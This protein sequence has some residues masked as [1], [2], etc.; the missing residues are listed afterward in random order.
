M[1]GILSV[2]MSHHQPKT[3]I[4]DTNIWVAFFLRDDAFHYEAI[5][6]VGKLIKQKYKILLQS[7]VAYETINILANRRFHLPDILKFIKE[8]L[9]IEISFAELLSTVTSY[10]GKV[11]LKSQ[12]FI[13]FLYCAKITPDLFITFDK[14]LQSA[15]TQQLKL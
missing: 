2:L 6:T 1:R 15:V 4:L 8:F 9:V 7:P 3:V 10:M 13:I 12:D 11:K 5:R 14:N